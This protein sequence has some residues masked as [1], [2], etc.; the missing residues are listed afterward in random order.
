MLFD[1]FF[2]FLAANPPGLLDFLYR[3]T[4]ASASSMCFFLLHGSD[5]P[6][7]LPTTSTRFLGPPSRASEIASL[8]DKRDAQAEG[9][10][11]P[12]VDWCLK[13]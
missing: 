12:R 1:L 8:I 2:R 4:R 5:L 10:G 9:N 7:L 6:V 13:V 3:Y 11:S